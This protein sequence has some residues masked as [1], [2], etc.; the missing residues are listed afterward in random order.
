MGRI[1]RRRSLPGKTGY[2]PH[3]L[4]IYEPSDHIRQVIKDS[5]IGRED[6]DPD[7]P[8]RTVAKGVFLVG[9][10]GQMRLMRGE[11]VLLEAE[12]FYSR[13]FSAS[14]EFY[15]T[16]RCRYSLVIGTDLPMRVFDRETGEEVYTAAEGERICPEAV[17]DR[18]FMTEVGN[19]LVLRAPSGEAVLRFVRGTE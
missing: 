8:A 6:A 12:H 19:L 16:A 7:M 3:L 5:G 1:K 2:E 4:L 17:T 14:G 13:T 9:G 15:D 11:E 10:A 18:F